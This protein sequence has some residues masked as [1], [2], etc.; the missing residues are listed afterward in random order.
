MNGSITRQ[1]TS[2]PHIARGQAPAGQDQRRLAKW[3]CVVLVL[4]GATSSYIGVAT[5]E[6]S[7]FAR[8]TQLLLAVLL[9]LTGVVL[10]VARPNEALMRV[11]V[12][13]G[14]C[15]IS[16]MLATA[17]DFGTTPFF[18]LW[19]AVFSA[20]FAST[21]FLAVTLGTIAATLMVAL[22]VSPIAWA[23]KIDIFIGTNL[24]VGMMAALVGY[25]RRRAERLHEQLER[26][27]HTDSLT[28]LLN[29]RGFDPELERLVSL[30]SATRAPLSVAMF[31][32]DHFK[33]F[34][35]AHGHILGDEALR[36]MAAIL[37]EQCRDVDLV[38]R[39]GGEEFVVVLPGLEAE[40]AQA[41]AERVA[42][43]LGVE[44]VDERLRLTTSTGLAELDPEHHAESIT[45][46]LTR[47]DQA[48]YAAKNG[49]RARAAWWAGGVIEVGASAALP[50]PAVVTPFPASQQFRSS[51]APSADGERA[52]A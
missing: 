48:L 22:V 44:V 36:R 37:A 14:I 8:D 23:V 7:V 10:A 4:L 15:A 12:L 25:M 38:A 49:G 16:G 46:L 13:L 28:G 52:S 43:A 51:A 2:S 3:V 18:Y 1:M 45:A 33:R 50:A 20:Y 6:M 34:N 31:D 5:L 26:A 24:S 32:L 27:A 11:A 47:A 30:A 17:D 35:D 42:L 41:L 29:R 21:R 9:T 39:F 19:P 40:G